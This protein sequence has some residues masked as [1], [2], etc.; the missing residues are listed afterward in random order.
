MTRDG[1]WQCYQSL[2]PRKYAGRYVVIAGGT[3]IGAGKDLSK[4]LRLARRKKPKET[5]FVARMR[6]PKQVCVYP[7][8]MNG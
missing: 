1:N 8:P 3:L 5:P 6:D 2:D 4:L 7:V